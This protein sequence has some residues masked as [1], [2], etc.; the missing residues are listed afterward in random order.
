M[1]DICP[2]VSPDRKWLAFIRVLSYGNADVWIAL[3]NGGRTHQLTRD[4]AWK[5]HV[6][7]LPDNRGL[8]FPVLQSSTGQLWQISVQGDA[9]KTITPDDQAIDMPTLARQG[10]R[11]AYVLSIKSVNLWA[12]DLLA[13]DHFKDVLPEELVVSTRS[14]FDPQYSPDGNR[15][16][17]LSDRS[18]SEEIWTAASNGQTPS[19]LSH[20][21]G[22]P[23]GSP[24]WS[25]DGSEIAFDTR[26]NGN[27]DVW[28]IPAGG[29]AARR[30]TISS[31]E[32]VVPS[33]SSDGKWIY[34]ASNRSGDFQMWKV[35]RAGESDSNPAV[36]VTLNG[37]FCGRETSDAKYLYF[38]KGRGKPGLWRRATGDA[39]AREEPVLPALQHWGW[40][41]LAPQGIL[42]FEQSHETV[43]LM[44]SDLSGSASRSLAQMPAPI[45]T[46][47]RAIDATPDGG[48]VVYA[49]IDQGGADVIILNDFI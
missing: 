8:V 22:P 27:P 45:I 23:T 49:Q 47:T 17:F 4:H 11:L 42:Y 12:I 31:A 33:W 28:V 30:V 41:T 32:D 20:I 44:L 1:G 35:N 5:E 25:H 2:R 19:Q 15:V 24:S 46:S 26:L 21:A 38:S 40:W 37:G 43:H 7:W 6:A 39:G 34:F 3:A 9:P 10:H 18:G 29:G 36:Q 13:E 48:R 16:A 14:Q